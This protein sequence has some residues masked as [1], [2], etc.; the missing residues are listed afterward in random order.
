M[1][2]DKQGG[3]KGGGGRERFYS[4]VSLGRGTFLCPRGTDSGCR[5]LNPALSKVIGS[6]WSKNSPSADPKR[7]QNREGNQDTGDITGDSVRILYLSVDPSGSEGELHGS[8]KEQV[9]TGLQC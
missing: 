1:R 8:S 4:W 5:N 7:K 3:G 6:S 9:G 2:E